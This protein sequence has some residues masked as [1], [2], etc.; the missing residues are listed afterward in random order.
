MLHRAALLA[1]LTLILQAVAWSGTLGD[2]PLPLTVRVL[3][4]GLTVAVVENHAVPVVTVEAAV[5]SGSMNEPPAWNG[6]SHLWEHMFFKGNARIPDQDAYLRRARELGMV[7]NGTTDTER[8]NYFFTLPAENLKPGLEFMSDALRSPRFEAAEFE[9]EKEV[10][11]GEFDRNEA[12]PAYHLYRAVSQAV[13]GDLATR[14]D[15]LG[16][17]DS[18]RAATRE[19]MM[20]MQRLYYVPENT[21]LVL[22]GDVT[23]SRAF[24]MAEKVFGDWRRT[25]PAPETGVAFAPLECSRVVRV[26]QPVQTVSFTLNWI[27][28]DTAGDRPG[29]LAADVFLFVMAQTESRL[30]KALVDGGLAESVEVGYTT[31]KRGGLITLSFLTDGA[32]ARRAVEAALAEVARFGSG[33]Y[34]TAAEVQSAQTR[35]AVGDLYDREVA[36][37]FSHSVSFWWATADLEYFRDYVGNIQAVTPRDL[38]AFVGRY[39]TG[40]PLVLGVLGGPEDMRAPDLSQAS[41]EAAIRDAGL[42][43]CK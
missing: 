9:R 7:W 27:G 16:R 42:E 40:R 41:L 15:P 14:K 18:V 31:R 25:G 33:D 36:H 24:P 4:N 6:L 17:R 28:P 37:E 21:L 10:V 32:R 1:I 23:P 26:T 30:Q 38:Q 20:Q 35:L 3:D 43:V 12:S 13:W 29:T 2:A 11:L 34:Y 22:A 8:V 5:K 39:V 19:D